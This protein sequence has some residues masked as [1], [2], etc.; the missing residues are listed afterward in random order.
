MAFVGPFAP[1][2]D[3]CANVT[4]AEEEYYAVDK[5][6]VIATIVLCCYIYLLQC[7]LGVI[8][9]RRYLRRA[10]KPYS[11]LAFTSL[12][13]LLFGFI[14]VFVVTGYVFGSLSKIILIQLRRL[15][16]EGVQQASTSDGYNAEH[17]SD[18]DEDILLESESN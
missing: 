7:I 10:T 6:Y 17:D 13:T 4:A 2:N 15:R 18:M 9:I 11:S 16:H 14:F 3:I 5:H 8:V 12:V 1:I